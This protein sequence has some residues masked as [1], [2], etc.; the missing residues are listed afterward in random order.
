MHQVS[1][2]AGGAEVGASRVSS[3]F[4][5]PAN[6]KL[7]AFAYQEASANFTLSISDSLGNSVGSGWTVAFD[8]GNF[9]GSS[10]KARFL[11]WVLDTGTS[12]LARTMTFTSSISDGWIAY[13]SFALTGNSPRIKSGQSALDVQAGGGSGTM[14]VGDLPVNSILGNLVMVLAGAN[15]DTQ[16][17]IP[18]PSGFNV[19]NA[20]SGSGRFEMIGSFYRTD[21]AGVQTTVLNT[22][23]VGNAFSAVLIEFEEGFTTPSFVLLTET[24]GA[25]LTESGVALRTEGT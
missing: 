4:T 5:P 3:S 19:L 16:A 24:G 25:L 21:F 1:D 8:S 17:A 2:N 12:P 9:N 18:T 6:A 14:V 23:D 7:Y 11:V 20:P 13:S 22:G 15:K 10:G